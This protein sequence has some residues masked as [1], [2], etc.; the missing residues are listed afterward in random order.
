MAQSMRKGA[1]K[2]T[3]SEADLRE[4]APETLQRDVDV[5][6]WCFRWVLGEFAEKEKAK[7]EA[8]RLKHPRNR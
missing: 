6:G 2:E 1:A 8:N 4:R 3:V 5:F 7:N